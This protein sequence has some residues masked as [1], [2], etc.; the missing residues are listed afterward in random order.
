MT[1]R[2]SSFLAL[3][4]RYW[5]APRFRA[6]IADFWEANAVRMTTGM[7]ESIF[8]T[9]ERTP[10]PS[11]SPGI[12]MSVTTTSKFSSSAFCRASRPERATCT[13]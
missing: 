4:S 8:L 5:K 2:I 9:P 10:S 3:F 11:I 1:S 13:S 7:L 6:S 12:L